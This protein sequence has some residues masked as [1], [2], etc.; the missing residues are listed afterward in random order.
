MTHSPKW[1]QPA[2]RT[3]KS[4]A[5]V[6]K[7]SPAE[8]AAQ[9]QAEARQH[10]KQSAL[11]LAAAVADVARLAAEVAALDGTLPP[12]I[13]QEAGALSRLNLEHGDRLQIL[14]ARLP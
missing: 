8:R 4:L 6:V 10:G 11:D 12:G 9:L 1:P 2:G 13:T 14:I 7:A 3:G 5:L